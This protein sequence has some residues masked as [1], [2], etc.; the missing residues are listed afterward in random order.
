MNL[1]IPE[2]IGQVRKS[3]EEY[4]EELRLK[5]AVYRPGMKTDMI[6]ASGERG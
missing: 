4:Y 2:L 5:P 1:Y 3:N 6:K